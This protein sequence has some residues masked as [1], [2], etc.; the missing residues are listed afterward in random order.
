MAAENRGKK[1]ERFDYM[2]AGWTDEDRLVP[3]KATLAQLRALGAVMKDGGA[4]ATESRI[5]A[6]YTYFGQFLDH[7]IT[8]DE[9]SAT[10][11]QLASDDLVP[12]T[13]L[14]ALRNSRTAAAELDSVYFLGVPRD[15]GN[16]QKLRLSNVSAVSNG[17]KPTL[18]P[19]GKADA[20][21][22]P[23]QA[24]HTDK[25]EDRAAIIGDPR[26]DENTIVAQ[27]HTAFLK[28]HNAL[29]KRGLSFDEARKEMILRYQ[30]VILDDFCKLVCHPSVYDDVRANGPKHWQVAGSDSLFMPAEFAFAAYRFGHS[31][32][33]TNYDFNLNFNLSSEPGTFPASL[34]LL[35]TFT[36]LSGNLNPGGPTDAGFETLPENWIIEWE[37]ILP[38][39]GDEPVQKAHAID[40]RLTSFLF[41][42]R[43][44]I[45]L[46]AGEDEQGQPAKDLASILATR[47]LLRGFLLGL[48]TGQAVARK[49]SLP[50][51]EGQ[52]LIDA[53]PN[54]ELKA[55]AEPFKDRSP[56]WFYVLAEAG[57]ASGGQGDT[58]GPVGSRI[59]METLHNLVLHSEVSI[60]KEPNSERFESSLSDIIKLAAESDA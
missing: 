13:D 55:A 16:K 31:M 10:I 12:L 49:M 38:L 25:N 51:L 30:S 18:R 26:N 36:A 11:Q 4:Q 47:N 57:A 40:A 8:L 44:K 35:F 22:L 27:L 7:D 19:T 1:V 59:V 54:Q 17:N 48:P 21:D 14:S 20:N 23:R 33:R 32:V 56:L 41:Q 24:R 39:G 29:V 15:P 9:G 37:R 53:L 3:S 6:A 34:D 28:A 45:G 58:L 2:F 5:P 60:L 52:A 46:P 43:N 50:V 42:L